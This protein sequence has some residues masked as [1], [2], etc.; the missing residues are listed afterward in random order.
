[1]AMT[2]T[3]LTLTASLSLACAG[4]AIPEPPADGATPQ[5]QAAP[6]PT[7]R[8]DQPGVLRFLRKR[9]TDM[10]ERQTELE[11]AIKRVEAG[12][13]PAKIRAEFDARRNGR[14]DEGGPMRGLDGP[15]EDQPFAPPPS[16]DRP[17]PGR[18]GFDRPDLNRP[19]ADHPG[20]GR[21]G[22]GR[23]GPERPGPLTADERERTLE[24]LREHLPK[25]GARLTELA[26][27]S[28]DRV[29]FILGQMGSRVP[30]LRAIQHDKELFELKVR[31]MGGGLKIMEARRAYRDAISQKSPEIDARKAELRA[32]FAEQHDVQIALQKRDVERLAKRVETLRAELEKR[33]TDRDTVIDRQVEAV[34]KGRPPAGQGPQRHEG[35]ER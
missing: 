30:E 6:K 20:Q 32:A 31:E 13:D 34:T 4:A 21:G 25:V 10:K 33:Q 5:S 29:D 19:A 35:D 17:G 27:T 1:M 15:E 24:F 22:P 28:P 14:R 8:P 11:S 9:L 16:P 23:P 18:S 12:E 2:R 7:E 3:V 26:K